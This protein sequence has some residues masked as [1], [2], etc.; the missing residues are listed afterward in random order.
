MRTRDGRIVTGVNLDAYVGRMAVCAEAVA[1]GRVAHR[2]GRSRASRPSSRCVIQSPARQDE[3]RSCRPAAPAA[4]S[5]TTT[6][7]RRASSCRRQRR[8][9][10]DHRRIAA[11]QISAGHDVSTPAAPPGHARTP[12]RGRGSLAASAAARPNSSARSRRAPI[13]RCS[14]RRRA[15]ARKRSTTC[16]S[17][18]RRASAR[19]RW[20]RSSRASSA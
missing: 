12:R 18:G 13:S 6:T 7:A 11:E 20:R 10:R 5:F 3:S 8:R 15:R 4:N 17:S 16:C 1:I 19:P 9:R 2:E 14:S